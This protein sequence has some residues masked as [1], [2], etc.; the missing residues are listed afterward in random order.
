MSYYGAL[1]QF[2]RVQPLHLITPAAPLPTPALRETRHSDHTGFLALVSVPSQHGFVP[3]V[4]CAVRGS[5]TSSLTSWHWA[6]VCSPEAGG[7]Q[8]EACL[9]WS[10]P[11]RE[12]TLG[13][14]IPYF[15][16]RPHG[17]FPLPLLL[18][19]FF[20]FFLNQSLKLNPLWAEGGT[21]NSSCF[22]V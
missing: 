17:G 3:S 21:L 18:K 9:P 15:V 7:R 11:R 1:I 10:Q 5:R 8:S 14:S 13:E 6:P 20:F 22:E 4:Q 16:T 12:E 19:I 2:M